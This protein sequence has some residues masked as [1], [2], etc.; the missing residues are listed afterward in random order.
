MRVQ[1]RRARAHLL[2]HRG[3]R[4]RRVAPPPEGVSDWFFG[5][6][7]GLYFG[8]F[9]LHKSE[10]RA[11]TQRGPR[12]RPVRL[13]FD[14]GSVSLSPRLVVSDVAIRCMAG[15]GR[16]CRRAGAVAAATG[17]RRLWDRCGAA[18]AAGNG[19][20]ARRPA[21]ARRSR[22]GW[23]CLPRGGALRARVQERAGHFAAVH[24]RARAASQAATW[25]N[26]TKLKQAAKLDKNAKKWPTGIE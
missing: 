6:F 9:R 23:G 2:T 8:L 24:A 5:S 13:R 17:S 12:A 7:F 26:N 10:P 1:E 14:C 21:G 15:K 3:S 11:G 25:T 18:E 22:H 19:G 20:V 16:H 4:P